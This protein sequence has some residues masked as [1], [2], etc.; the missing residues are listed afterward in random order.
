MKYFHSYHL[1]ALLLAIIFSPFALFAQ[2]N[3]T[4]KETPAE[5]KTETG[6]LRG[7]LITPADKKAVPVVLIISGSGPTDRDGNNPA[8]KNNHLKM[9]AEELALWG[10]ASL[11]Y[12]K[13]GIAQSQSAALAEKDLRFEHYMYDAAGWVKQ[14]EQD[15]RF[16]K[17]IVLGHSEGSLIGMLAARQTKADAFV[18]LAG[19]GQKAS[20]LIRQQLQ[21]QP[22]VVK[23]YAFPILDSLAMGKTVANT[24]PAFA[25]LFRPS[26]QPYLIS[27][28][29]Y[30]PQKE[31]AKLNIPV[32]IMQGSNDLQVSLDEAKL[33][34]GAKPGSKL[35]VVDEMNHILKKSSLDMQVNMATYSNPELPLIPQ[36]AE[37]IVEFINAVK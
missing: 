25:A 1:S 28:F 16:N 2:S 7:S 37:A 29:Q 31:I 6:L 12:D 5:L 21:A 19:A 11:R 10:I 36:C 20:Q 22:Q 14:L 34:A 23:D 26:V 27:W 13:R 30:D 15:K 4:F 3:N 32:L 9:L 33:L 18:S 35:I 24:D 17:V 8:M